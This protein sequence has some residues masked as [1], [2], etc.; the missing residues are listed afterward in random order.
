[1][2]IAKMRGMAFG[3]F[4]FSAFWDD[5]EYALREYVEEPP[6]DDLIASIETELGGYRLPAAYVE[7]ARVHNGGTPRRTAFPTSQPTGWADDHI[8]ITGLAAIGRS[9]TNS[10][11]GALGSNFMIEEWG[12]PRIGVCIADTP[13]A[14]HEMIMLDY[15]TCGG[16]GEP[17]VV[18]VD[19]E[20][21]YDITVLAPNFESFIRGLVPAE[22][23]D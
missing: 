16:T 11:C 6:T 3:D 14:G 13:T 18:Y 8:K 20:A 21:D 23:F 4:D 15:R 12:Y 9:K 10:L 22:D 7:L 19:Q 2:Q 17:Q 5:S 1:M